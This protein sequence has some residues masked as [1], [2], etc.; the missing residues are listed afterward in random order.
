MSDPW[1]LAARPRFDCDLDLSD[2]DGNVFGLIGRAQVTLRRH[3]I[4]QGESREDATETAALVTKYLTSSHS[5]DE[6]LQKLD[7]MFIINL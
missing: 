5:Y 1:T 7:D 6:V 2:L 4:G 3:L